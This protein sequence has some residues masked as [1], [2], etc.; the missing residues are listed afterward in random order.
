MKKQ[1]IFIIGVIFV[2]FILVLMVSFALFSYSQTGSYENKI[3]TATI[4][5]D[6]S[7]DGTINLTNAIPTEDSVGL[8]QSAYKFT[9][10]TSGGTVPLTYKLYLDDITKSVTSSTSSALATKYI[11]YELKKNGARIALANL[12]TTTL[13]SNS[14]ML[15]HTATI[16]ANSTDKYE[17]RLWLDYDAGNDAQS[18]KFQGQIRLVANQT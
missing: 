12:P 6:F 5:F 9:V 8:A 17:L 3:T 11:R 7:E 4:K 13:L 2:S 16:Q 14:P 15:L 18:R 1:K 10:T